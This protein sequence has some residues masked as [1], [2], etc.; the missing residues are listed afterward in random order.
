[1][2]YNCRCFVR[3]MPGTAIGF[4]AVAT[5]SACATSGEGQPPPNLVPIPDNP[6]PAAVSVFGIFRNGHMSPDAWA[7]F[8]AA[9]SAPFSQGTCA[10]AYT[11]DFVAANPELTLAIDDYTKADGVSE[12]LLDKFAPFAKADTILVV[13]ITGEPARPA[14]EVVKPPKPAQERRPS[15]SG[16]D[17][18]PGARPIA[19]PAAGR[20]GGRGGGMGRGGMGGRK[21]PAASAPRP[22]SEPGSWE[23]TAFLYSVRPRRLI[24]QVDLTQRGQDLDGALKAFVAKLASELPGVPCRGWDEGVQI[25]S[26]AVRKLAEP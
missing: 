3:A 11:N 22:K 4:L 14:P 20:G 12:Q 15:G 10:A 19:D 6:K 18:G 7:E 26:E 16:N 13:A 25:D 21:S 23:L 24:G 9:L 1:M 2:P 8:G 5:L 17:G